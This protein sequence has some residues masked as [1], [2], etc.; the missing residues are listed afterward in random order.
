[1]VNVKLYD[2]VLLRDGRKASVVEIFNDSYIVDIDVG[3][4]YDTQCVDKSEVLRIL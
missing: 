3:G 2:N 1:M 4:D